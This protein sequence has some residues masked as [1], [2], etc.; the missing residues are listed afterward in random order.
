[1]V[2]DVYRY[3]YWQ[4]RVSLPVHLVA[5]ASKDSYINSCGVDCTH[6]RVCSLGIEALW[7]LDSP[8]I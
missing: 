5:I 4:I 7:D 2:G 3:T 1:M 8:A 6:R